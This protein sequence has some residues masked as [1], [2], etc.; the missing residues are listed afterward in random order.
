M[1]E[2]MQSLFRRGA[3]SG[4]QMDRM[5]KPAILRKTKPGVPSKLANFDERTKDEGGPRMRG[6]REVSVDEINERAVQDKGRTWGTKG[7]GPPTKGGRAGPE[8]TLA[9]TAHI[10]DGK[11]V[12]PAFPAG[13]KVSG[14]NA[15]RQVGIKGPPGKSSGPQ[16]GGPSSRANG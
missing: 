16:Y 5:S 13:A 15:K 8:R 9:K 6:I 2:S 4:K 7:R 3:I 11:L 10:D 12:R 1:A 14:K